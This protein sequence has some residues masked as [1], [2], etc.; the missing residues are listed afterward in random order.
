MQLRAVISA[1]FLLIGLGL[2]IGAVVSN[3]PP[4]GFRGRA[5]VMLE[6]VG[7]VEVYPSAERAR[8]HRLPDGAQPGS[9]GLALYAGDEVRVATLSHVTLRRPLSD[10]SL[11]DG[12][13]VLIEAG[14]IELERGLANLEVRATA[15]APAAELGAERVRNAGLGAD[16]R[17]EPGQY[18][19]AADG[20]GSFFLFVHTGRGVV[21]GRD[22]DVITVEAGQFLASLPGAVP[23]VRRAPARLRLE[24][25]FAR[26]TTS[27]AGTVAGRTQPGAQVYLDGKLIYPEPDGTFHVSVAPGTADVVVFARDLAGNVARMTLRRGG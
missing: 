5:A 15:Y 13:R 3:G 7:G 24:A 9:A 18:R 16:V 17:L 20:K 14:W 2:P 1:V 25:I 4:W 27:S 23:A 22:G 11:E 8:R 21:E 10:V 12:G 19:A 6:S 26:Q